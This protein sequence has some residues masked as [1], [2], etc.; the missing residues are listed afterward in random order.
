MKSMSNL[1]PNQTKKIKYK[2]PVRHDLGAL[3]NGWID[4][5]TLYGWNGHYDDLYQELK[6]RRRRRRRG[7]GKAL[8]VETDEAYFALHRTGIRGMGDGVSKRYS[9]GE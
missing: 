3:V 5:D 6:K 1:R 7:G 2:K 8:L 9:L 4:L